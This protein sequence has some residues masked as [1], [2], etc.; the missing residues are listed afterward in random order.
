MSGRFCIDI[1]AIRS[2]LQSK[3]RDVPPAIALK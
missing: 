3:T 2:S 1:T